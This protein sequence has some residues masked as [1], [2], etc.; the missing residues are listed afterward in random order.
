MRSRPDHS[1]HARMGRQPATMPAVAWYPKQ[2]ANAAEAEKAQAALSAA[3]Q[4]SNP[5]RAVRS[6]ARGS[7]L[8]KAQW[9]AYSL[10]TPRPN[11]PKALQ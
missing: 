3:F 6:N 7:P 11:S 9:A 1:R 8:F 4:N 10:S 2:V 5:S